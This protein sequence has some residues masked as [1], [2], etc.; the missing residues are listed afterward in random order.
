MAAKSQTSVQGTAHYLNAS[1]NQLADLR[2]KH[3]LF[4]E[5][6]LMEAKLHYFLGFDANDQEQIK[7]AEELYAQAIDLAPTRQKPLWHWGET[8][9]T[10]KQNEQGI[11]KYQQAID[12]YPKLMKESA[13]LK[14]LP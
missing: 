1:I 10:L 8:L 5:P 7:K 9:I 2:Q 3:P 13:T 12:L 4:L 6:Y 11:E 14:M